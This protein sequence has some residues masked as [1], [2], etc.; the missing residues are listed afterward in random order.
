MRVL[1]VDDE[2]MLATTLQRLLG[3]SF[4]ADIA[5]S[6]P[7]ALERLLAAPYEVVLCD[8]SVR[9]LPG[10]A[11]LRAAQRQIPGI[12]RR[13]IFMTGGAPSPQEAL[14]LQR[15]GTMLL[16]KPFSPAELLAAIQATGQRSVPPGAGS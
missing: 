8:L 16:E 2:P 14:V 12:E 6:G 10:L 13:F 3:A 15:E 4:S 11:L 5:S 7:E 9:D 1:I